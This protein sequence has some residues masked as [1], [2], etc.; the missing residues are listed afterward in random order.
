MK[1]RIVGID[2]KGVE[3]NLTVDGNSEREALALAKQKGIFATS[4]ELLSEPSSDVKSG[5]TTGYVYKM[6][7]IPPSIKLQGEQ[8]GNEAADYLQS[9]VN[10]YAKEGWEFYRVDSIGVQVNPGCLAALLGHQTSY[11]NY[12]VVTFR[13]Q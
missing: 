11:K 2:G 4:T 8:Q 10:R 1:F 3:R 6:V 13:R 9:V 12:F 5:E 7:Q